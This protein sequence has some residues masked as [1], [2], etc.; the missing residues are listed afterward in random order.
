M[1]ELAFSSVRCA[2]NFTDDRFRSSKTNGLLQND[3]DEYESD[4][5][6]NFLNKVLNV[7]NIKHK[8]QKIQF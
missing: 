7:I 5:L 1:I 4:I 3:N 6:C 2:I 8:S